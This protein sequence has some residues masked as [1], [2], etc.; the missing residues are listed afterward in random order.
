MRWLN[1]YFTTF[2]PSL[3][4]FIVKFNIFFNSYFVWFTVRFFY[5]W[6]RCINSHSNLFIFQWNN[7][8]CISTNNISNNKKHNKKPLCLL[9]LLINCTSV[10]SAAHMLSINDEYIF[11]F[12]DFLMN[13]LCRSL[14]TSWLDIDVDLLFLLHTFSW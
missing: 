2:R 3:H 14:A 5:N 4:W 13:C 6:L 9:Y 12:L 11:Y 7:N 10:R 1:F 8:P